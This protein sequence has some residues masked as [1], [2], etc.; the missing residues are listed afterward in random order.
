MHEFSNSQFSTGVTILFRKD[1]NLVI[2]NTQRSEDGRKLLVN[3]KIDDKNLTFVKIYTPNDES[4][5]IKD[6]LHYVYILNKIAMNI[7]VAI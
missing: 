2:Q 5:G 6:L 7:Y 1:L 3:V 4:I